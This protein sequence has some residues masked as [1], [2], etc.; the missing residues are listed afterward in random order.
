MLHEMYKAVIGKSPKGSEIPDLIAAYGAPVVVGSLPSGHLVI[1]TEA[2]TSTRPADTLTY[3][4]CEKALCNVLT[5]SHIIPV[6]NIPAIGKDIRNIKDVKLEV[7]KKESLNNINGVDIGYSGTSQRSTLKKRYSYS[8]LNAVASAMEITGSHKGKDYNEILTVAPR[9]RRTNSYSIIETLV[10]NT[11]P[12]EESD[13]QKSDTSLQSDT[14]ILKKHFA[15]IPAV[16]G[17]S[18]TLKELMRYRK[19]HKCV[20]MHY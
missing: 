11:I 8:N 14:F 7:I 17:R 15:T 5:N 19:C 4:E 9:L 20:L 2:Q 1:S 6:V 10:G 3:E 13:I 18:I 16:R 12:Y